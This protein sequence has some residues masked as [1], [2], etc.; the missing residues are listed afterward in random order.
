MN[1]AVMTPEHA[2]EMGL[3]AEEFDRICTH[4]GR[5][6]NM[7]ELGIFSAMWSEH[8]SYKSSRKWLKTLPTKG[9]KVIQGPGENAGVVDIGDGW[10]AVFKIESHNHP[11]F[12]EPYQGAATGVGGILRDVF[13]MGARPVALLNALRFGD[14]EDRL[15]RYL[16]SGVVAGIGGYG[17]CIGIPTVGGEVDFNPSYNRNNLVNAMAVGL[18]RADRIFYSAASG[19][20]NPVYYIGAKTG[21]DGIHG[22]TM[23]SAEFSDDAA[24]KRPTVQVGDPFAGKLLLE[25]SLE[26]MASGAVVAIQDMGAAGLT[27]SSVEMAAKGGLGMELDLDLVPVREEAMTPYEIMLSESQERMLV[28]LHPDASDTAHAILQKW[29]LDCAEIGRVTDSGRL[30]LNFNGEVAADIPLSP[31]VDDAPEYDRPHEPTPASPVWLHPIW[32]LTAALVMRFC[33]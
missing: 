3:T 17:N 31:L 27:S 18:A 21:R 8:C 9:E 23:A 25:A 22:A 7:T 13:T 2:A 32:L 26:L 24:S 14:P 11:S 28:V 1:T 29:D 5:I 19:A 30:V 15:T 4:I 16:V 6:P 12:I 20:G 33:I 10:A